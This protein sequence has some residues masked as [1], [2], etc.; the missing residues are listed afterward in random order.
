VVAEAAE[1]QIASYNLPEPVKRAV[2]DFLANELP[3]RDPQSFAPVYPR[4][5]VVGCGFQQNDPGPPAVSHTF[6]FHFIPDDDG[7]TFVL[8]DTGYSTTRV[9]AGPHFAQLSPKPPSQIPI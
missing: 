4:R 1:L 5:N 6:C 3:K 7:K 2:Y 8:S 9:L